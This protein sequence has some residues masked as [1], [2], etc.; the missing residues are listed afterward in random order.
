MFGSA[1]NWLAQPLPS[2]S[3]FWMKQVTSLSGWPPIPSAYLLIQFTASWAAAVASGPSETIEPPWSLDQPIS[4]GARLGSAVPGFPHT[5]STKFA[6][7][8][9]LPLAELHSAEMLD[10]TAPAAAGAEDA[11][12]EAG[13]DE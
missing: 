1:R 13:A 9:Q 12:A 5:Y 2:L 4:T 6:S 7:L 3:E 8:P 11:A 10:G